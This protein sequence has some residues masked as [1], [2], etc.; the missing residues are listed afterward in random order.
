MLILSAAK[1]QY[2]RD[3]EGKYLFIKGQYLSKLP[4][5]HY[6]STFFLLFPSQVRSI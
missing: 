2:Y 4:C 3:K 1:V 6:F 5:G